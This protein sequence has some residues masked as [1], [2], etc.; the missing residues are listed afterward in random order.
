MNGECFGTLHFFCPGLSAAWCAG[1]ALATFHT[2]GYGFTIESLWTPILGVCDRVSVWK[3]WTSEL[4]KGN[5]GTNNWHPRGGQ[6]QVHCNCWTIA[7][8][9]GNWGLRRI[10]LQVPQSDAGTDSLGIVW[11]HPAHLA[12]HIRFSHWRHLR[13]IPS[14]S[15]GRFGARPFCLPYCWCEGLASA[16][17]HTNRYGT[18]M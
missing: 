16:L 12:E 13:L 15:G 1:E 8:Y 14:K 17:F 11:W 5:I 10:A 3:Q 4:R 2:N 9:I 18:V 6:E 7:E